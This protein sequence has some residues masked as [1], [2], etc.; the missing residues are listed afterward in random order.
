MDMQTKATRI[1]LFPL[2]YGQVRSFLMILLALFPVQPR[3][4]HWRLN[5]VIGA[6]Y[7]NVELG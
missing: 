4:W 5:P 6:D 2:K 3:G 1:D 7:R